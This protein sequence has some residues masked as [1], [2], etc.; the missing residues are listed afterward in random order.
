MRRTAARKI[1][2]AAHRCDRPARGHSA[3]FLPVKAF[4]DPADEKG[5]RVIKRYA[6]RKLY[7]TFAV[8]GHFVTL[9]DIAE[10]IR[11]GE[12]VEIVEHDGR[13]NLTTV[14]LAQIIFRNP[15]HLSPGL[16][17]RII[18]SFGEPACLC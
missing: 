7:D 15:K 1:P 11:N 4:I 9:D 14:F 18:R 16:L 8:K 3:L 10:M 13:R 5:T 17:H 12:E 2:L 6:T